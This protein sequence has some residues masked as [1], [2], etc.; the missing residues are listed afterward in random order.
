MFPRLL[1]MAATRLVLTPP[2]LSQTGSEG[3]AV[4]NETA[5]NVVVSFYT[6]DAVDV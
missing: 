2:V 4:Q 5:N 3:G 6:N 1:A